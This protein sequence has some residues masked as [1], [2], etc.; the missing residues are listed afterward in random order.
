MAPAPDTKAV[1]DSRTETVKTGDGRF[2]RVKDLFTALA[3][4]NQVQLDQLIKRAGLRGAVGDPFVDS[5]GS[6]VKDLADLCRSRPQYCLPMLHT[7]LALPTAG[8][9]FEGLLRDRA[10]GSASN[11]QPGEGRAQLTT[12]DGVRFDKTISR[13]FWETHDWKG[14]Y[15]VFVTGDQRILTLSPGERFDSSEPYR[16]CF[17]IV[18]TPDGRYWL[19]WPDDHRDI[20]AYYVDEQEQLVWFFPHAV[21]GEDKDFEELFPGYIYEVF[22]VQ[23]QLPDI[24]TD[25]GAF[26]DEFADAFETCDPAEAAARRRAAD[27][28]EARREARRE[29]RQAPPP[30]SAMSEEERWWAALEMEPGEVSSRKALSKQFRTLSLRYHPLKHLDAPEEEKERVAAKYLEITVAYNSLK[31]RMGQ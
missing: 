20:P 9:R 1:Y 22:G 27:H 4:L 13:F 24:G 16:I 30:P 12:G 8:P 6:V 10:F 14:E 25:Y 26:A 11:Q 21:E 28:A 5:R 3:T 15:Q 19:R 29:G 31:A 23:F 17:V 7:A 18:R 2:V